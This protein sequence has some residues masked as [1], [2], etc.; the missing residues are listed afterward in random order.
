MGLSLCQLKMYINTC[1]CIYIY[2]YI[3]IYMNVSKISQHSRRWQPIL[4][5]G[6]CRVGIVF[7][8]VAVEPDVLVAVKVP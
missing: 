5:L 1:M 2:I 3:D 7:W 4:D 8:Q 6:A